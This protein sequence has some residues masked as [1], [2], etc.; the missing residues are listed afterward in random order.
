[1]ENIRTKERPDCQRG[2]FLIELTITI[3]V[4]II[5]IFGYLSLF[6]HC[7]GLAETSANITFAT[8]EAQDKIEEIRN[9]QF[10]NIQADYGTAPGNTFALTQLN[11]TGYIYV[12]NTGNPS[13]LTI[14]IAISW[15]DKNNRL[16]GGVDEDSDG[17]IDSPVEVV[18]IIAKRY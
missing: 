10:E 15:L 18:T 9:H 7:L 12:I 13:L 11:G 2:F 14:E 16:I 5:V 8:V 6:V 3:A 4:L 17:R 1:M